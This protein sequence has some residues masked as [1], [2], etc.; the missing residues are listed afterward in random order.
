VV[1][2]VP[3][4]ALVKSRPVAPC[5]TT[6]IVPTVVPAADRKVG[7]VADAGRLQLNRPGADTRLLLV[8]VPAGA[9]SM[10]RS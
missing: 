8:T 4:P 7:A 9:N 6:A 2:Q 1:V 5:V 10:L 3:E